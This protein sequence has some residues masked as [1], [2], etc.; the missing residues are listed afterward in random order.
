MSGQLILAGTPIGNAD[1]ATPRLREALQTADLVAAEDT[2]KALRLFAQLGLKVTARLLSYHDVNEQQRVKEIVDAVAAGQ[3]VVVISD[4]GMPTISDPGF[5]VAQAASGAGLRVTALPGPSAVTVALALSGLPT[6]R[7]CFEGFLSR[8]DGE[9]KRQL[10]ELA[11][12][13]R[14]MVFFESTH[15]VAKTTEQMAEVF[16]ADRPAALCRELTKTYEEVIRGSIAEIALRCQSEVLGEI[17]LVVAGAGEVAAADP[18]TLVEAVRQRVGLGI[19]QK[20]AIAEVA[21]AYGVAKRTVFDLLV[22]AKQR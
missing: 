9:R 5:R 11:Q 17:T 20:S 2:R 18:E 16:G 7:F 8:K 1:D 14:T 22:A 19:D 12:E 13:R 10:Q 3:R 4:A 6:D 21:E 15:R